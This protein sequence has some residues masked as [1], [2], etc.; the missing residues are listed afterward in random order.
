MKQ[1]NYFD[2]WP[3][4]LSSSDAQSIDY[5][6]VQELEAKNKY[7]TTGIVI[8]VAVLS[9][10]VVTA[11]FQQKNEYKVKNNKKSTIR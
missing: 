2:E 8:L 6:R 11:N 1:L 4:I 3:T 7:L 9:A 10:I 5:E